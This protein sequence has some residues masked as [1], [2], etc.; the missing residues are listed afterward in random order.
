M[1]VRDPTLSKSSNL[2]AHRINST[3]SVTQNQA[4]QTG[5][6]FIF[7]PSLNY[8]QGEATLTGGRNP[9]KNI[10][11]FTKDKRPVSSYVYSQGGY[12]AL[13]G[14][15]P[16][17]NKIRNVKSAKRQEPASHTVEHYVEAIGDSVEKESIDRECIN[18][19]SETAIEFK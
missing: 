7:K 2:S 8:L 11:K 3:I 10:L 15:N 18:V 17:T 12:N 6:A 5:G 14:K 16:Q 19:V 4:M 13:S 9:Q 1:M